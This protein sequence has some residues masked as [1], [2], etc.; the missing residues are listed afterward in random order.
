MSVPNPIPA[1]SLPP[2]ET[3]PDDPAALKAITLM[4]YQVI[5]KLGGRVD[6]LQQ[7]VEQLVRRMFGRSSE[8]WDPNQILMDDVLIAALDQKQ[9]EAPVVAPAAVTVEAHTRKITPHGRSIFPETLRREEIVVPVPT[10]ERLCPV[11]G[12]E[13]PVI[14]YEITQKLEFVR[15]ELFVKVYKREKLG[16]VANAEETGVITAPAPEGPVPKGRLDN[17]LLA[18]LV[19]SKFGDHLPLYRLET[20]FERDGV[21][22]SRRT[23]C[24]NLLAASE[25]LRSLADRI[26][27][28]ILAHGIVHHDDTPVD[29]VTEGEKHRANIRE[30]R[31]WVAT[32]PARDGPWT[33]FNFSISR[34]GRHVA[35]YFKDYR[36][37]LMSD[38]F[39]GYSRLNKEW[40]NRLACWVHA[41]RKFFEAKD[42]H[43][44]ESAELLERVRILYKLEG[45]ID[46]AAEHDAERF[47]MRQTQALP[48]L[49]KI[50]TVLDRWAVSALPKS[51]LGKAVYY[52]LHNWERLIRYADDPRLPIDNNAA[53]Q[54]IRPVAIG[55]K[56]WLFM[57]SERGGHAAAVYM[58]LMATCKRA[59]VNPFDYL[60]DIFGRIMSHSTHQLDELLPGN[61]K[62]RSV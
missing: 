52:S 10:P 22:L 40:V 35:E 24:D 15:P 17:G 20:I 55:R 6:E 59:G 36:G 51:P 61:W 37:E 45:S 23:M 34:E 21:T 19:V 13:R 58:T 9:P 31:L 18:H 3:L 26:R 28:K 5:E 60:R 39:A 62:P 29:M 41:R 49:D 53:E 38:D 16:S 7:Q 27:A 43:P 4:C 54:A 56:N 48:E 12:R 8:K 30:A 33:H 2:F 46:P 32:V 50:K 1:I 11:T 42:V 44:I 57:G 14:G 25:P 47:Q